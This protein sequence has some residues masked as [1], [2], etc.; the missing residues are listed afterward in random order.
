MIPRTFFVSSL[1]LFG[2]CVSAR[3]GETEHRVLSTPESSRDL[4]PPPC[5]KGDESIMAH[6]QHGSASS[7]VEKELRWGIDS[8]VADGICNFNRDMAEKKWFYVNNTS[9]LKDTADESPIHF[10]SV[11]SGKLV[12][13]APKGRTKEDFLRDTDEHGWPSFRD[14]EGKIFISTTGSTH[15]SIDHS[16]TVRVCSELGL[17]QSDPQ[18]R[19]R[20]CDA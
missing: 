15:D 16:R 17:C 5:V 14:A 6:H 8:F 3:V 18:S 1:A 2:S 19:G 12:F 11:D 10:Y 7:P 4:C 9:F 20:N 13:T